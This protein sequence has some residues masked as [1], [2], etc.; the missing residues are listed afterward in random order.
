M[1]LGV[2]TLDRVLE[3]SRPFWKH[4]DAPSLHCCNTLMTLAE[5][6]NGAVYIYLT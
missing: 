3:F 5:C 2:R 1:K 4:V 6:G